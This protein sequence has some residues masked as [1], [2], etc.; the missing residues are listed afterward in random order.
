MC[1]Q[2]RTETLLA[3]NDEDLCM[4]VL[5]KLLVSLSINWHL[6]ATYATET[7][8]RSLTKFGTNDTRVW[9]IILQGCASNTVKKDPH[10]G[11]EYKSD[12]Y[13]W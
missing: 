11:V 5:F 2:F 4:E 3:G 13:K 1:Y 8:H 9:Q 12:L 6:F 7:F 10:L